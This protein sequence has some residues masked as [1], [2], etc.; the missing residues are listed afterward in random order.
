MEESNEDDDMDRPCRC[1]G[2]RRDAFV[3]MS[4]QQ[5][6]CSQFADGPSL[7]SVFGL[8]PNL[9][10]EDTR[11]PRRAQPHAW[12]PPVSCSDT[13]DRGSTPSECQLQCL[14]GIDCGPTREY[15]GAMRLTVNL[16][17]LPAAQSVE[18]LPPPRRGDGRELPPMLW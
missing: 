2:I 6:R 14:S 15:V 16:R 4:L 9:S 10:A 1:R 5:E 3:D 12:H 7:I 8:T 17:T 11:P 13:S 18:T